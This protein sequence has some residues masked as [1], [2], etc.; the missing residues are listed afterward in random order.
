VFRLTNIFVLILTLTGLV[1]AQAPGTSDFL[2][3]MGIVIEKDAA[4]TTDSTQAPAEE[5]PSQQEM[6]KAELTRYQEK[7]VMT[8]L[9]MRAQKRVID[10]LITEIERVNVARETD[11]ALLSSRIN[12]LEEQQNEPPAA[13]TPSTPNA[14]SDSAWA[15]LTNTKTVSAA[16]SPGKTAGA[17]PAL[18]AEAE[19]QLYRQGLTKFHQQY[20]YSAIEDFKTIL[21]R[22]SDETLKASAQYWTGRSYYEKEMYDEAII[23]FEKV[24]HYPRSDKQDDA[25]AMIGLAFQQKNDLDEAKIAFRELVTHHPSSEYITLAKRFIRN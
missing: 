14:A 15:E 19:Q 23:A 25:L 17:A 22:G 16:R 10:S 11:R 13:M 20:H 3:D 9:Q 4:S 24:K 2:Y 1:V 6:L 5:T 8:E 21:E 7:L 12:T 18:T